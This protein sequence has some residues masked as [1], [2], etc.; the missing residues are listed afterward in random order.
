METQ[1]V[2]ASGR[3]EADVHNSAIAPEEKAREMMRGYGREEVRMGLT[4]ISH[5][6]LTLYFFHVCP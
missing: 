2:A 3:R 6:A 5:H 1:H 4:H